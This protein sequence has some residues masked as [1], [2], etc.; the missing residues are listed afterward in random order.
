MNE[1][2]HLVEQMAPIDA[3]VSL[4][5]QEYPGWVSSIDTQEKLTSEVLTDTFY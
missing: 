3:V 5:H 1:A 2:L 4:F